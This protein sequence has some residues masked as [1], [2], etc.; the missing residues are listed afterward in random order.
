MDAI[1]EEGVVDDL[2]IAAR[3]ALEAGVAAAVVYQGINQ[4]RP[5]TEP[6]PAKIEEML[7]DSGLQLDTVLPGGSCWLLQKL[8]LAYPPRYS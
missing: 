4:A 7:I 2:L 1:W 3:A 6:F 8:Q 5:E